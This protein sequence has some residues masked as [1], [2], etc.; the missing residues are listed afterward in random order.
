MKGPARFWSV[1]CGLVRFVPAGRRFKEGGH[2]ANRSSP[3][4]G[5]WAA[6]CGA[7]NEAFLERKVK[8]G[9]C[10]EAYG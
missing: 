4:L 5:L 6:P 3:V 9:G 2:V 7:A 1:S 10:F 8:I